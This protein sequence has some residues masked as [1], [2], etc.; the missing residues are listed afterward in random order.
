MGQLPAWVFFCTVCVQL[1]LSQWYF[2][3]IAG[4]KTNLYFG[5]LAAIALLVAMLTSRHMPLR[6]GSPEVAVSLILLGLAVAS[7][8][9]SAIP[10]SSSARAFVLIA[11]GLGGFWC[12][13]ILVD[14]TS[15]QKAF[16]W[17]C[18]AILIVLIGLSLA[19]QMLVGTPTSLISSLYKNAHPLAN[20]LLLL[21]FAPLALIA[22]K[23]WWQVLFGLVLLVLIA[24]VL[25]FCAT[26]GTVASAVLLAPL[27]VAVVVFTVRGSRAVSLTLVLLTLLVA[28]GAYFVQYSSKEQFSNPTYQ[29]YRIESYP[30]SW[31]VAKSHPLWG[32]G[33]RAPR[34]HLLE[35]YETWHPNLS[36]KEFHHQLTELV[37]PENTFLA[38]LTGCGIPFTLVYVAAL[39][40]LLSRLVRSVERPPPGLAFHPLVLLVSL[41]GSLL[42]SFTTDTMLHGQLCW[43]FHALLGLIPQ[44]LPKG[45]AH[46]RSGVRS[47]VFRSVGMVAAILL[48]IVVGTH[49][50]LAPDKLEFRGYLKRIPILSSFYSFEEKKEAKASPDEKTL[51]PLPVLPGTLMVTL[52]DLNVGS[53]RWQMVFVVDNSKTMA[54]RVGPWEKSRLEVARDLIRQIAEKLPPDC[55]IAVRCFT[56]DVSLKMGSQA[57]PLT[58]SQRIY[59]WAEAPFTGLVERLEKVTAVQGPADACTA[60]ESSSKW[61]FGSGEGLTPRIVLLTD[62]QIGCGASAVSQITRRRGKA[63]SNRVDVI[64]LGADSTAKRTLSELCRDTNGVL[65]DVSTPAQLGRIVPEYT[66]AVRVAKPVPVEISGSSGVRRFTA[67][68][69]ISLPPGS[70]SLWLP[71]SLEVPE[72]ERVI[73]NVEVSPEKVTTVTISRKNGRLTVTSTRK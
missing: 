66:S 20:M 73:N 62:G 16:V 48:G 14:T 59:G 72:K 42:H 5:A 36:K 7:G 25:Y 12:T 67:G 47:L 63:K 34:Q 69:K 39:L 18:S 1:A 15:R 2:V 24:T 57:I 8:L 50:A 65:F 19:G 29:V 9:H 17:L 30:F 55:L 38:L 35:D 37:T 68:E 28:A 46:S 41:T 3:V 56:E 31:H 6:A 49:P 27:V 64:A 60:M 11:T 45:E 32:V 13:R 10:M 51:K 44:P 58:V 23:R 26:A 52:H 21:A 53:E 33:L 4:E 43:F 22:S 70:Y 71:D 54:S 40:I 61:D